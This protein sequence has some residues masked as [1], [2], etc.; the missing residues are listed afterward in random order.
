M[1]ATALAGN[2]AQ[3]GGWGHGKT[4]L[5]N[6]NFILKVITIFLLSSGEE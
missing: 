2:S 1:R 4:V 5:K 6:L 3:N